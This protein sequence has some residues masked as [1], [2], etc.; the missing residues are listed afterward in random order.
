M[1]VAIIMGRGIE[2][3]GVTKFTVEQTKWLKKNGY[4]YVRR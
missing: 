1:K 3:C 2:G 4:D